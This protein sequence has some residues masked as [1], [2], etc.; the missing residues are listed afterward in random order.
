MLVN[1]KHSSRASPIVSNWCRNKW[2]CSYNKCVLSCFSEVLDFL[3]SGQ[4]K[5]SD[6][7]N[8]RLRFD[9]REAFTTVDIFVALTVRILKRS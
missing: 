2:S 7:T 3:L 5:H 9:W 6:F 8:K 1:L 4:K